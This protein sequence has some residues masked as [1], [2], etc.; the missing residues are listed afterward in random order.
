MIEAGMASK[1]DF[2]KMDKEIKDYM[3]DETEI[4][5]ASPEPPMSELGTD[6]LISD[7]AFD[8]RGTTLGSKIH[9]PANA[10][11]YDLK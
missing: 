3:D 11:N 4:A 6:V 10:H 7:V 9:H 5:L 2:K 1:E 8:Q